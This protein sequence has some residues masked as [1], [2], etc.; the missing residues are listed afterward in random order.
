[1]L[2]YLTLGMTH[3]RYHSAPRKLFEEGKRWQD[4]FWQTEIVVVAIGD[5]A[6]MAELIA[7]TAISR[8]V[9][10]PELQ[11]LNLV[12]FVSTPSAIIVNHDSLSRE[13]TAQGRTEITQLLASLDREYQ[14]SRG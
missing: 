13:A 6:L 1:M 9:Y 14:Q 2:I 4:R 3:I 10:D 7:K 11:L 5:Q 12:R 8:V